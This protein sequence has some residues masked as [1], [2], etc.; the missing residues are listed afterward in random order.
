MTGIE[1]M[2]K[3]GKE[4]LDVAMDNFGAY[5]KSMQ[6]IAVELSDYTK[7]SMEDGAAAVESLMG[8]KS[9]DKAIEV[10]A[11]YARTSFDGFVSQMSKIGE[12]YVD[13]ARD[14]YKPFETVVTKAGK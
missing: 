6:A 12:I 9:F 14:A 7:K 11:D 13:M 2:Q 8:A 3:F 4:N 10:Q 1:D 5:A